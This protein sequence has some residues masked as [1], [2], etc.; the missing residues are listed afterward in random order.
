MAG[1]M[2][3]VLII[4]AGPVGLTAAL[5]LKRRGIHPRIIDKASGPAGQSRALGVNPRT[6][7][8]FEPSGMTERLLA[9]GN[10]LHRAFLVEN[11][12]TYVTLR[13][14]RLKHRYPFMLIVPQ[15]DTERLLI[16]ALEERGV[17]VEWNT[18]LMEHTLDG[19]RVN[20]VIATDETI[21]DATPDYLIGADGAHSPTR[22]FAGLKF[23][24]KPYPVVF[25]LADIR[26]QQPRDPT[27]A[28]IEIVPG[29]A[30]ASFPIDAHTVRH[31]GTSADVVT[32]VQSRRAGSEIVWESEFHVSFRHVESFSNGPVFLAGDAAHVHSPVGARG[33]NLGIE[34]A[35]WLAWLIETGETERYTP[36]RLPAA[37]RVIAFTRAQTDQLFQSGPFVHFIRRAVAPTLLSLSFVEQLALRRLAGLDTPTP[38]WLSQS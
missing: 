2:P 38:P 9:S 32:L 16:D 25:A 36:A 17:T 21:D 4:G 11:G 14:E 37:K 8:I 5:E 7:E 26:Y 27:A 1:G 33:M 18:E 15:S 23:A 28:T 19:G 12:Q 10:R 31:V 24:G 30:V 29:G 6:L 35:A 22:K 3:E 20:A 34:D 13:L